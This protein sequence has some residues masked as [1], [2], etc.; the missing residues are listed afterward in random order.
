[1]R[2]ELHEEDPNV[3]IMLWSGIMTRHEIGKYHEEITWVRKDPTKEL[4][5]G[6][7]RRP[8]W[9]LREASSIPPLQEVR[10][11]WSQKWT[12]QCSLHS[13]RHA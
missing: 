4:E 13:W 1:M 5:F 12:H 3:N 10:T 8:S 9:K 11:D 7:L 2:F 6:L